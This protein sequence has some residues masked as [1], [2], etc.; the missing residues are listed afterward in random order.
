MEKGRNGGGDPGRR[1]HAWTEEVRRGAASRRWSCARIADGEVLRGGRWSSLRREM[2]G[3]GED[4]RREEGRH[5]I[6][7]FLVFMKT[8][9]SLI[10][11]EDR[12]DN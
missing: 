4:E 1:R 9:F 2:R 10:T 11:V 7:G 12:R 6:S 8:R 3:A 5:C